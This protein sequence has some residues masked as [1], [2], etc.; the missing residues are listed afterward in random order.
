M[1]EARKRDQNSYRYMVGGGI[2]TLA[3]GSAI[4][5]RVIEHF[6]AAWCDETTVG[7][8]SCQGVAWP[9]YGLALAAAIGMMFL[10]YF[11]GLVRDEK[12]LTKDWDED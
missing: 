7:N 9:L 2:L 8:Y 11:V 1:S 4:A 12:E 6:K 3:G 10:L 5:N